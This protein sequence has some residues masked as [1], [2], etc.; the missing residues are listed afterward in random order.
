MNI[1]YLQYSVD[2]VNIYKK[3]FMEGMD[4]VYYGQKYCLETKRKQAFQGNNVTAIQCFSDEENDEVLDEGI[5]SIGFNKNSFNY[6]KLFSLI[7][8]I[9]PD[10]VIA[11][12]PDPYILKYL[13]TNKIPT[14]IML[15]DS[16]QKLPWYRLKTRL[17]NQ[18]LF[19]EFNQPYFRWIGN[20]QI[21]ATKSLTK[22]G[23]NSNKL[24]PYDWVHDVTPQNW[25]INCSSHIDKKDI[26]LFFGGGSNKAKGVYDIID[27]LDALKQLG[28]N[29]IISIAGSIKDDEFNNYVK[30]NKNRD[31][32]NL[33]GR[34]SHEEVLQKMHSADIVLV[35]SH[36]SY[37]EGLPMTIMESLMVHTPVVV[38]DHPMFVG[39]VGNYG[40]VSFFPEKDSLSLAKAIANL[41]SD[42]DNYNNACQNT[43]QEWESLTLNTKWADIINKWIDD[44]VN[45]DFSEMTIDKYKLI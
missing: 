21:N 28:R 25:E 19:N 16:F 8:H 23:V 26:H 1:I 35:P 5:R 37:P 9:K 7:S 36:H 18:L 13:R 20:H 38:S 12:F 6:K 40:S 39:R 41:C 14:L 22:R 31:N 27:C 17:K 43:T 33:L 30:S 2:F 29:A 42:Q 45:C 34:I 24:I 32:I 44:P 15:A 4:E 3:I 10:R 11:S